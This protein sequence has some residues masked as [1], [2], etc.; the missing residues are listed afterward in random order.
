MADTAS[1]GGSNRQ[2]PPLQGC[3]VLKTGIAVAAALAAAHAYAKLM[4]PAPADDAVP[5]QPW[6]T[7][8]S[9]QQVMAELAAKGR[10]VVL[11]GS[12]VQSSTTCMYPACI[13]P[14][15]SSPG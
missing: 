12:P 4:Q 2:D 10:P 5:R 6:P 7:S 1:D 9:E 11:T 3:S 13:R 8:S 14:D 15:S